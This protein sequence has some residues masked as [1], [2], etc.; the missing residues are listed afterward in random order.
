MAAI[1]DSSVSNPS[2]PL[3]FFDLVQGDRPLGRIVMEIFADA[4]PKTAENFRALCTGEITT[5]AGLHLHYKGSIFHRVIKGFMIQG[6]DFTNRN[7]TGGVSVYGEKFADEAFIFK[8]DKPFLLSM[9]NAGKNTN[10]SQ[11]FITTVPTPH[12]DNKHVIFGKV[13]KGQNV[14]RKVEHTATDSGDRPQ[15][16]VTIADCGQL[17]A[18]ADINAVDVPADGDA[19]MDFPEDEPSLENDATKADTII[20][21]AGHLK[22]LGNTAFKSANAGAGTADPDFRVAVEKYEKA[23]RY[24]NEIPDPLNDADLSAS[25]KKQLLSI[26]VSS[27]LN[28]S[29]CHLKTQSWESTK[30]TAT[31]ALDILSRIA[32]NADKDVASSATDADRCKALFRRGQAFSHSNSHEEA[33]KDMEEAAKLS[34]D[35]KLIKSWVAKIVKG[36]KDRKEKERQAYAKMFQ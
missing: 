19:Y 36:I 32:A 24:V 4:V 34:P 29:M 3:C 5:E 31:Q 27:L 17:P 26:K 22:E 23:V 28:L 25:Q 35:D 14:V 15:V 1:H 11:F 9:A 18:G 6:G 33:L 13:L 7:G 12:L 16:E 8:H 30:N 10:G 20:K 2:N 21:I